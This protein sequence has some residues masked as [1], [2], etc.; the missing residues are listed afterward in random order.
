MGYNSH[1]S[2][3]RGPVVAGCRRISAAAQPTEPER[4]ADPNEPDVTGEAERI[5]AAAKTERTQEQALFQSLSL[6]ARA[7]PAAHSRS[8]GGI[9]YPPGAP[10]VLT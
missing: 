10:W 5:G 8:R 6:S 1:R 2:S 9:A 4:R 7:G 3:S